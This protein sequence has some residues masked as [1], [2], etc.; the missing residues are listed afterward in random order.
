M[1]WPHAAGVHPEA[2]GRYN[3]R[4]ERDTRLL[5]W[6]GS[7]IVAAV[8]VIALLWHYQ[9]QGRPVLREV[10]VVS[11]SANDPVFRDGRR[12]L[13][14]GESFRLA[15][16]LL[17]EQRGRG[18]YWLC[19]CEKL[20]LA[21][22]ET[23]HV[24]SSQWPDRDR[25]LRVFWS[26][27]E[28]AYLGGELTAS[29]ASQRL[30]YRTFLATELGRGVL[31]DGTLEA[32]NDDFLAG[33]PAPPQPVP[34]TLRYRARVEISARSDRFVPL[35]AVSSLG[36]EALPNPSLPTISRAM[37][38]PKGLHSEVGEL[39][40]LPGFVL[41]PGQGEPADDV[42]LDALGHT[43]HE[44]VAGRVMASSATF[45]AVALTGSPVWNRRSLRHL[46]TL[47]VLPGRLELRGRP[48]RWGRDILPGDLIGIGNH[49]I[50]LERDNGNELLDLND[51]VIHCWGRPPQ[52]VTLLEA[53]D[54]GVTEIDLYR[55]ANS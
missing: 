54:E 25:V 41:S 27:I 20:V 51:R 28:C 15:T 6:V 21:G 17:V 7:A 4:M 30:Q 37:E 42:T 23:P 53:L 34:G 45:A 32:H 39:F 40:F 33:L 16:A 44:L 3:V 43:V 49:W 11:A 47:D 22:R 19:P 2:R 29:N 26:T 1:Y 9:E 50:V 52:E 18:Q 8:V 46:G 14:P 35:Q 36:P 55:H 24:Q 38:V 5:V 31:V 13:A 48:L 12:K 10:R